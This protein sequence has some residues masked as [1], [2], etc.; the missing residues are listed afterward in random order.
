MMYSKAFYALILIF[1][2]FIHIFIF[3]FI[4]H[5]FRFHSFCAS[6]AR[7]QILLFLSRFFASGG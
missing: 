3:S 4:F 5:T 2:A 7:Q 1:Y 6:H